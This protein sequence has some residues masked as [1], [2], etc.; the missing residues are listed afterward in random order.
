MWGHHRG[1][2]KARRNTRPLVV[3]E[4]EQLLH[5]AEHW[6]FGSIWSIAHPFK[7]C[8][9]SPFPNSLCHFLFVANMKIAQFFSAT[10]IYFSFN[11]PVINSLALQTLQE[12]KSWHETLFK[13]E[14]EYIASSGTSIC[15]FACCT[16]MGLWYWCIFFVCKDAT[17]KSKIQWREPD[18]KWMD[19]HAS[20]T[21]CT[22]V[23][24]LDS[25]CKCQVQDRIYC[26]WDTQLTH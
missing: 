24:A 12:T 2:G 18:S 16:C 23:V 6:G 14:I 19:L 8:T 21:C 22:D 9:L 25:N 7:R 13:E 15:W 1:V 26:I 5:W 11:L 20:A 17:C 3:F 10:N 4:N